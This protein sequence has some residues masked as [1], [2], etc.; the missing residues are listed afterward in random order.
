MPAWPVFLQPTGSIFK[1]YDWRN[2]EDNTFFGFAKETNKF[3]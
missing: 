1:D 2:N 3:Y